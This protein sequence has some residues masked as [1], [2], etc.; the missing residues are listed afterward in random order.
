MIQYTFPLTET[1]DEQREQELLSLACAQFGEASHARYLALSNT[2]CVTLSQAADVQLLV[3]F[4]QTLTEH[5]FVLKNEP[6]VHT[7][8][9][10]TATPCATPEA[11]TAPKQMSKAPRRV[12]MSVFISSL[13]VVLVLAI[14]ATFAVTSEM[15]AKE[16]LDWQGKQWD[17]PGT[18]VPTVP[19]EIG[20]SFDYYTD[21]AI[22]QFLF[23]QYAI[24][25]IDDEAL[26]TA[27]L[28]AYA[29]GTGDIYAEYYTNEELEALTADNQGEMQGIGVSV[30]NDTVEVNGMS[31]NVLT[32]ISVYDGSPA[33]A[34]GVRVG[35]HLYTVTDDEGNIYSVNELGYDTAISYVRGPIDTNAVFTVLRKSTDGYEVVPFEIKRAEITTQ[36]V[37]YR[38]LESDPTVGIVKIS[39]FDLTTPQQFQAAMDSLIDQGCAKFVFDVRYN[40]GG[41]LESIE[42]IL[43][44]FL[45]EGDVMISTVYKDGSSEV[46]RVREVSYTRDGYEGC[47]VTKDDIGKYRDYS[48]AVLTNEYTA[49]AAELFTSDLRDHE[50]ATLVGETTYGKGCMQ[51]TFDL[52]YFGVEGALKLTVAWYQPAGGENYHGVGIVPDIEVSM[53]DSVIEKYGNIYLIPDAE[54]AQLMAAVQALK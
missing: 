31:Y 32:I 7:V 46:D 9:V 13:C 35:D 1:P 15:Y 54:D 3:N 17:T 23:D 6:T 14:L 18:N 22:L 49:S 27:V 24:E 41:I 36:S 2:L 52:S 5:G 26:A 21:L 29:A 37:S 16:L 33:L 45:E 12:P 53:D 44:T 28:K 30:V 25:D 20:E 39:Q 10:D 4:R 8:E 47:S 11:T 50:L 34:A 38:V 51:S 43:S 42:A 19:D 48:F 40:P